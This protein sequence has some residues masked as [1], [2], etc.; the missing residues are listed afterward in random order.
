MADN[1]EIK[2]KGREHYSFEKQRARRL[3]RRVEAEARQARHDALTTQEKLEKAQS[4]GG[5]KREIT[6]LINKLVKQPEYTKPP[7]SPNVVKKPESPK[8]KGKPRVSKY[9][10]KKANN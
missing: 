6:R 8:S 5:S 2:R 10:A 3:K 7:E 1:T 9:R 4:R